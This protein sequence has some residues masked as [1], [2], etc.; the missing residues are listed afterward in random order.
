MMIAIFENREQF[1]LLPALGLVWEDDAWWLVFSLFYWG[2]SI[3]V[4]NYNNQ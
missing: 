4:K 3:R 2:L 1:F